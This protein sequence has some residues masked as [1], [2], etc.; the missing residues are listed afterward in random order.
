MSLIPT[1]FLNPLPVPAPSDFSP[2]Q[3]QSDLRPL[4]SKVA[5][6]RPAGRLGSTIVVGSPSCTEEKVAIGLAL[7]R[8]EQMELDDGMFA[9]EGGWR[10]KG[11]IPDWW[12][13]RE[14]ELGRQRK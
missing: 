10:A 4:T 14:V 2:P 1:T 9:L 5:K 7:V 12:S 3:P 13:D 6:P 11:F 8:L